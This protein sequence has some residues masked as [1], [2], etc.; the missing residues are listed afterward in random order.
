MQYDTLYTLYR[1]KKKKFCNPVLQSQKWI[2]K[3]I[4]VTWKLSIR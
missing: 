2:T 4:H 3:V 1:L